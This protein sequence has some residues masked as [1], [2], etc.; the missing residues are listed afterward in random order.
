VALL[1]QLKAAGDA[2]A[3]YAHNGLTDKASR[4]TAIKLKRLPTKPGID[5][6][7]GFRNN[8][9]CRAFLQINWAISQWAGR[10]WR[11]DRG[12]PT[13]TDGTNL[14]PISLVFDHS[15]RLRR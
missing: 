12:S 9:F 4:T 8:F 10:S 3:P 5:N 6:P 11:K 14:Y 15:H 2:G 7:L 1:K 13:L